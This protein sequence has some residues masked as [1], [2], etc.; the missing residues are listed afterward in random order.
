MYVIAITKLNML[1][2]RDQNAKR[3]HVIQ[4]TVQNSVN[5]MGLYHD[6]ILTFNQYTILHDTKA[7]VCTMLL[8]HI[9]N[10]IKIKA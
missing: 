10:V 2:C 7:N 9:I 5:V 8:L 4:L 3:L 6:T 1:L